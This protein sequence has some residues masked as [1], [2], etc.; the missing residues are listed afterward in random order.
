MTSISNKRNGFFGGRSM[1]SGALRGGALP[2]AVIAGLL[3]ASPVVQAESKAKIESFAVDELT[4]FD[5]QGIPT[6][7]ASKEE[8]GTVVHSAQY[9]YLEVDYQGGT[10]Y[11]SS[12]QAN[13]KVSR[14]VCEQRNINTDNSAQ[15]GTMGL[16]RYC[17][18][19]E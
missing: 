16:G 18:S 9:G 4:I 6:G 1:L 14:T 7:K 19:P 2:M 11:I 17:E 8:L 5:N 12:T 10:V 15:D 3:L 13:V